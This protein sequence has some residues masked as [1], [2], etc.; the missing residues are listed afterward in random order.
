MDLTPG[1]PINCP[2][3]AKEMAPLPEEAIEHITCM[4]CKTRF[5]PSQG[6]MAAQ[7]AGRAVRKEIDPYP[8]EPDNRPMTA[9]AP[10]FG[11]G[12]R[13]LS[14]LQVV[15]EESA[16]AV[17]DDSQ[18][19]AHNIAVSDVRVSPPYQTSLV[20][21]KEFIEAW[22]RCYNGHGKLFVMHDGTRLPVDSLEITQDGIVAN[23]GV[24]FKPW[25]GVNDP[26]LDRIL[27]GDK[28]GQ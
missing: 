13:R 8:P 3:C 10:K 27:D 20:E 5:T 4:A 1:A 2:S 17:H 16:E 21:M 15:G 19:C 12:N 7:T 14:D 26:A 11:V 24:P 25:V 18:N 6:V 23:T 9:R 28:S 22:L